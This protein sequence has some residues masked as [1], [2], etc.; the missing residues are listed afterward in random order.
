MQTLTIQEA[1]SKL[2]QLIARANEGEVIVVTDGEQNVTLQPGNVSP[3]EVDT[4][5]LEAELLKAIDGPFR[6]FSSDEMR[7]IVDRIIREEKDK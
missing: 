6:P 5:E 7:S 3:L 4:P 2:G 1:Q